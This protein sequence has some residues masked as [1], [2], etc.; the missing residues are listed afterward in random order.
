MILLKSGFSKST[1]YGLH[2]GE[3]NAWIKTLFSVLRKSMKDPSVKLY[4]GK[5]S[6]DLFQVDFEEFNYIPHIVAKEMGLV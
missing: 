1:K 6:K 3:L 2:L 4:K 5:R